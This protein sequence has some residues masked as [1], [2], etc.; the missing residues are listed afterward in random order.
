MLFKP[1]PVT[2]LALF[3][4][5]SVRASAAAPP[6]TQLRQEGSVMEIYLEQGY[7]SKM[8]DTLVAW[9]EQLGQA[10]LQVYGRWPRQ[11]WAV[12]LVPV[13]SSNGDS[14]PFGRV[15][16]GDINQVEFFTASEASLEQ[17]R[18]NW[19]GY[20]ELA[21]LLI[22]YRGWGDNWF[23][24]GLATYYQNLLQARAGMF[25]EERMW[26]KFYEGFM[27]GRAQ[28]E[29]DYQTLAEVT[30]SV[31]EQRGYMRMYWSGTWYFLAAD[32][33]LRQRSGGKLNLDI[34]LDRLNR[35]CSERKMSVPEMT[36][37]LDELT[38]E[39][40]FHPL[41]LEAVARRG[42]PAFEPLFE[43][44]GISLSGGK[45]RLAQDGPAAHMRREISTPK[46]L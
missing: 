46:T 4:A 1:L 21:H 3:L 15:E 45:L 39:A 2:L 19:T 5:V 37:K 17:L 40:L 11:R 18:S 9:L 44:L 22:P 6:H 10:L 33:A 16:R 28:R 8:E 7:S 30:R 42:M 13:S 31:R 29:L 14:I 36:R 24:E 41:Y 43:E 23:S 34:A 20:H 25:D 12:K 27:R 26:Q 38:G 32:L 35:C